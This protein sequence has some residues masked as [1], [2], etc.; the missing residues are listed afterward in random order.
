MQGQLLIKETTNLKGRKEADVGAFRGW[1]GMKRHCNYNLK[2]ERKIKV[3]YPE[4]FK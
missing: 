3:S 1:K 4:K 2:H